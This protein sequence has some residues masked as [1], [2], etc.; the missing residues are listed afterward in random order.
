MKPIC[1]LGD[2]VY[3]RAIIQTNGGPVVFIKPRCKTLGLSP[4][5]YTEIMKDGGEPR[6]GRL[7]ERPSRASILSMSILKHIYQEKAKG[8][9]DPLIV[10]GNILPASFPQEFAELYPDLII[11]CGEGELTI[12]GL[13]EYLQGVRKLPS[14]PGI[15]YRDLLG[16]IQRTLNTPVRDLLINDFTP[17]GNPS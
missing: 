17:L 7:P 1:S 6:D 9:I 12:I 2:P 16:K 4:D 14:I 10:L 11:A 3:T 8:L 15:A 13:I 5:S